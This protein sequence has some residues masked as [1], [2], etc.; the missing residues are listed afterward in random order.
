MSKDVQQELTI[1]DK[2]SKKRLEFKIDNSTHT[3]LFKQFFR[4]VQWIDG[5]ENKDNGYNLVI[6]RVHKELTQSIKKKKNKGKSLMVRIKGDELE[7]LNE[8]FLREDNPTLK[9]AWEQYQTVL[10]LTQN[11]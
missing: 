9:D 2:L 8:K 5:I 3:S 10:R 7:K 6:D 4:G 11:K 1:A